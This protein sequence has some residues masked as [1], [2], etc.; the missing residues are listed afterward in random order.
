MV[1]MILSFIASAFVI[2][3]FFRQRQYKNSFYP[4][5]HDLIKDCPKCGRQ[6][7]RRKVKDYSTFDKI[8]YYCIEN[9][10]YKR[11][12][13][14]IRKKD[15][16]LWSIGGGVI[17]ASVIGTLIIHPLLLFM[18]MAGITLILCSSSSFVGEAG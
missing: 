1:W 9:C 4:I 7:K 10:G 6:L 18:G 3:L 8:L 13:E 12:R 16:I 5:S 17:A 2:W 15:T 11:E 14:E